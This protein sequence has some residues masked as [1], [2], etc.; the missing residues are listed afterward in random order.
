MI[1]GE[2]FDPTL[3]LRLNAPYGLRM[4]NKI[5]DQ[6]SSKGSAVKSAFDKAKADFLKA[7]NAGTLAYDPNADKATALQRMSQNYS[8]PTSLLDFEG[9]GFDF[10]KFLDQATEAD[11][12]A[13]LLKAGPGGLLELLNKAYGESAV[14]PL[15]VA[16]TQYTGASRF[17]QVM[18]YA[19]ILEKL[20]DQVGE[21]EKT[22]WNARQASATNAGKYRDLYDK[23]VANYCPPTLA[24]DLAS[25]P[26]AAQNWLNQ[27]AGGGQQQQ[28]FVQP[29]QWNSAQSAQTLQPMQQASFAPATF[30]Q[31]SAP[32]QRV[33]SQ[34]PAPAAKPPP[35][36]LTTTPPSKAAPAP[37]PRT[38]APALQG[39]LDALAEQRRKNSLYGGTNYS[40]FG[41]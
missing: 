9:N 11:Q 3:D 23:L 33:Q 32:A 18:P 38:P 26:T 40:G 12:Q 41:F 21:T 8:G 25:N 17:K 15:D 37:A 2:G 28:G 6:I 19:D 30:Q 10:Q 29:P 24:F 39:R 16:E 36:A 1:F 34:A 4:S 14:R 22:A 7:V 27:N 5:A 20:G 13:E 31:A 35:K